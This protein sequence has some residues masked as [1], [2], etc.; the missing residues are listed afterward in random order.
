MI[1]DKQLSAYCKKACEKHKKLNHRDSKPAFFL[2]PRDVTTQLSKAADIIFVFES[3]EYRLDDN[4]GDNIMKDKIF[5]FTIAKK[6]SSVDDFDAQDAACDECEEI[7]MDFISLFR[8]DNRDYNA[9]LFG[10]LPIG[11]ISGF[12]VGPVFGGYYGKRTEVKFGDSIDLS[13]NS[14]K[15]NS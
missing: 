2:L 12:K 9:Q 11:S 10:Y 3:P 15:W 4:N 1:S 6:V 5:A 13:Y 7:A 14:K 8:K